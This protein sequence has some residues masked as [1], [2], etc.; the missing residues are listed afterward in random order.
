MNDKSLENLT[1]FNKIPPE[2]HR[3]ISRKGGIASGAS[4]IRK[5]EIRKHVIE[6]FEEDCIKQICIEEEVE[7]YKK[8][9]RSKSYRKFKKPIKTWVR[10]ELTE[11]KAVM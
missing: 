5:A 7:S 8:W 6:V 4:R 3:E 9:K 1:L 2:K 10:R 11:Q